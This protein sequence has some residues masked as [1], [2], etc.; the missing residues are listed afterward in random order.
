MII[1]RQ[2]I[3]SQSSA[4][5]ALA[6]LP[7]AGQTGQGQK[8][9]EARNVIRKERQKAKIYDTDNRYYN[10]AREPVVYRENFKGKGWQGGDVTGEARARMYREDPEKFTRSQQRINDAYQKTQ[11]SFKKEVKI[12]PPKINI[13]PE[14]VQRKI[15]SKLLLAGAAALGV[16]G[17]GGAIFTRRRRTKNGKVIV[18]QVRR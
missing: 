9:R 4:L 15:N 2:R 12:D 8:R 11:Q 18:E 1:A 16:A 10:H 6:A 3:R 7:S 17:I 13:E 14:Q 5:F